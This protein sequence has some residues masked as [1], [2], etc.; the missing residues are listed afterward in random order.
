MDENCT[1][2][3]GKIAVELTVTKWTNSNSLTINIA[4]RTTNKLY[5]D[6]N[7]KCDGK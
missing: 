5:V 1:W 6:Y 2:F 7:Y 4:F 3:Q